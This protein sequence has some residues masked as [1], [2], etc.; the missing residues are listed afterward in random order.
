MKYRKE[1]YFRLIE[2][3]TVN[4]PVTEA[5]LSQELVLTRE[6]TSLLVSE[7]R[8]Y[9]LATPELSR[10]GRLLVARI[11]KG[12]TP[13]ELCNTLGLGRGQLLYILWSVVRY[14]L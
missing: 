4:G 1:T 10:T 9:R 8:A 5:I 14:F 2:E 12:E 13:S 6:E 7:Y 3:L 11:K